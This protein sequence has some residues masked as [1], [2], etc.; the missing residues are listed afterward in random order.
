MKKTVILQ[1]D[2]FNSKGQQIATIDSYLKGDGS[3]PLVVVTGTT[4]PLG[5]DDNGMAILPEDDDKCID[6]AQQEMMK[7]AIKIQK[8]LSVDNGIDPK[9]V[10]LFDAEKE[11]EK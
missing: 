6:K 9:L 11:L 8:K 5:Y 3:T 10:N 7:E 4:R 1:D 2:I